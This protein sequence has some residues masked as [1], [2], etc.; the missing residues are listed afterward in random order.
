MGSF[1]CVQNTSL[2]QGFLL[3][4]AS[5]SLKISACPTRQSLLHESIT[6]A[7]AGPGCLP[8]KSCWARDR[9]RLSPVQIHHPT[10]PQESGGRRSGGAPPIRRNWTVPG[11]RSRSGG[12]GPSRAP[13][14][15]PHLRSPAP[16]LHGPPC[17]AGREVEAGG[18]G[19]RTRPCRAQH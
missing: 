19:P 16:R 17:T 5:P 7:G 6:Q 4:F 11:A 1:Q 15:P 13:I 2:H 10:I 12:T 14:P 9:P 3:S 8:R 18:P